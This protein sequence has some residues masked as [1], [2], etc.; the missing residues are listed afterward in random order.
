MKLMTYFAGLLFGVFGLPQTAAQQIGLEAQ[1]QALAESGLKLNDGVT[2]GD[3]L[4]SW[5][6]EEYEQSP[7]D[8]IFSI[9]GSEVERAPWG[10]NVCDKVWNFDV[11]S[12]EGDGAYV[13]IVHRLS[14]LTGAVSRISD[15][16][17]SVNFGSGEAWVSY[18][19]DG[20]SR[21]H[22]IVIDN[23]WA[24]AKAVDAVMQDML[25]SDHSFYAIDNG[26]ASIWFFLNEKTASELNKLSGG[27]L[28]K[29]R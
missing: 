22:N 6:R 8:L 3:L 26:Q 4:Y 24:D 15:I 9:Y 10:R 23:D 2:V 11:E 27:K 1:I 13:D 25:V 20:K 18:K 16:K 5:S 28:K 14:L 7:Y 12:I 21:K 29:I 17:D 19:I